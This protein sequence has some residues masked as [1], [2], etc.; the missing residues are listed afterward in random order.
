MKSF[1]KDLKEHS[2]K[3][4]NYEKKETVPLTYEENKSSKKLV[5]YAKKNLVQMKMIKNTIKSEIIVITLENIEVVL[6]TS[7][8]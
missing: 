7:A 5:I 6:I 2:A 8:I 1:C 3:I 4:I